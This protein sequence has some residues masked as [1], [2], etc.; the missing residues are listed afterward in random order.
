MCRSQLY[1][2]I[3]TFADWWCLFNSFFSFSFLSIVGFKDKQCVHIYIQY[4]PAC[5]WASMHHWQWAFTLLL[6]RCCSHRINIALSKTLFITSNFQSSLKFWRSTERITVY[7]FISAAHWRF[8]HRQL[9]LSWR[10]ETLWA[11]NELC[12][13]TPRG[14]KLW[15]LCSVWETSGLDRVRWWTFSLMRGMRWFFIVMVWD[16]VQWNC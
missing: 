14:Q 13:K 11:V 16:K 15:T 4:I 3:L 7:F 1:F 5:S 2:L 12:I 6:K 10:R 9:K 8:S